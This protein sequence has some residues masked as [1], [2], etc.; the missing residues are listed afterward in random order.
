MRVTSLE[1]QVY[2]L[3]GS[4]VGN[5]QPRHRIRIAVLYEYVY[6]RYVSVASVLKSGCGPK[7]PMSNRP[8]DLASIHEGSVRT[9]SQVALETVDTKA[10]MQLDLPSVE[11]V[12]YSTFA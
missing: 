11:E 1:Y 4:V 3:S 2:P 10:N 12:P 9:K 8:V 6:T 5:G 7:L